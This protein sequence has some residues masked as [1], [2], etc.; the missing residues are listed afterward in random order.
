MSRRRTCHPDAWRPSG[1][2]Y[3]YA[4]VRAGTVS[5]VQ[6]S[7]QSAFQMAAYIAGL[8][9]PQPERFPW[10]MAASCGV[11]ALAALLFTRFALRTRSGRALEASMDVVP[12][13]L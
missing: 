13:D 11:V 4:P 1:R 12:V 6:G 10:L 8:A 5:G 7:L 3:A 2:Y 9:V